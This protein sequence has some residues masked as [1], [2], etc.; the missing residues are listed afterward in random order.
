MTAMM[1]EYF[2]GIVGGIE[3]RIKNDPENASPR[4]KYA[5]EVSRLGAR[6]YGGSDRVAWC[7]VL[8]PFDVLS[9]FG[10]ASCYVEFVGASLAAS[11]MAGPMLEASEHE[12]HSPDTCAY[13]RAVVGAAGKGLM[14]TPDFLIATSC[15][16]TA[17][18]T[19]MENLARH[20]KK[21]LFVLHIPQE[22]T[23]SNVRYLTGQL[24]DMVEFVAKQTGQSVDWGA[25]GKAVT[26]SNQTSEFLTEIYDL[27]AS[28][29][30]PVRSRDLRDFGVVMP[31]ISGTQAA[32]DTAKVFRDE[33]RARVESGEGGIEDERLRLLWIQNRIQFKNPLEKILEQEHKAV[34]VV[35][36]LNSVTWDPV[37]PDDP[38]PGVAKRMLSSPFAGRIDA[39][40]DHLKK[41]VRKYKVDGVV[42]PCHWGCRQGTGAR[43]LFADTLRNMDIPVLNLEV[44]CVDARSFAEGQLKTR[45]GAFCEMLAERARP[46]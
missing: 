34:V 12:G 21:E 29:P 4:M 38:L 26:L 22:N 33:L 25:I 20:F 30:S 3:E 44:D 5:L 45:I 31:L 13:H 15:P 8:A 11:G 9:A 18:V 39:R 43:G 36:E 10:V 23:D 41:L 16:C 37:D 32:L 42:N 2:D 40:C 24:E 14:P 46:A 27:A 17:G 1:K 35:D 7:G 19:T 6:L 28:V